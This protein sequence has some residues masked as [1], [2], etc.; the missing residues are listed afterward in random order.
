VV[1]RLRVP[2]PGNWQHA[3]CLGS[4]ADLVYDP[5]FEDMD[6][7]LDFCNGESDGRVCP[8]REECLVF[9]L[10]NN[11]KEGVWGGTSEICRRALRKRWPLRGREPRPEW[12]WVTEAEAIQ[13]LTLQD[14]LTD[15]EEDEDDEE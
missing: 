12:H 9:A 14:L 2:A 3:K 10:T 5:F 15:D 8:I 7:A 13:G 4:V 6:E 1:L 11:L